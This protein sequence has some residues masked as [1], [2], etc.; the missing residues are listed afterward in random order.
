MIAPIF[1]EK[2]F[3]QHRTAFLLLSGF[4]LL[5]YFSILAANLLRSE[6][7]V[8][9]EQ[10]RGFIMIFAPIA[11]LILGEL[12]IRKEYGTKTQIFLEA[13]P[14]TRW[15]LVQTKFLLG[16]ALLA[17]MLLPACAI[18]FALAFGRQQMDARF[19]A[20]LLSRIGVF[21]LCWY[22]FF[23]ITNF[24]GRYR[25]PLYIF[26]GMGIVIITEMTQ[27]DL[28]RFGPIAL[29]NETFAFERENFPARELL[30]SLLLSL[31]FTAAGFALA[32]VREGSVAA[33]VAEK[34]SHRE[35]VFF[36]MTLLCF[37]LVGTYVDAKKPKPP[38]EL[39]GDISLTEGDATVKILL[40]EPASLEPGQRL[41]RD[42]VDELNAVKDWLAL[43]KL[44]ALNLIER[45]DLDP[46]QH[47]KGALDKSEGLL[48]RTNF[49]HPQWEKP[50]FVEKVIHDLL[51]DYS[52]GR[53]WLEGNHWILD[54]FALAW[55][56]RQHDSL[57]AQLW[58]RAL[59][60]TR[61][62]T[63][64]PD[65]QQ[66]MLLS[67]RLGDDI[68][69]AV[70]WSALQALEAVYGRPQLQQFLRRTLAAKPP[71]DLR[72]LWQG[73]NARSHNALAEIFGLDAA[74]FHQLWAEK[75]QAAAQQYAPA[76]KTIPRVQ[77]RLEQ[78]SLSEKT[79]RLEYRV[80]LGDTAARGETWVKFMYGKLERLAMYKSKQEL[81]R[82]LRKYDSAAAVELPETYD[83][84]SRLYCGVEI[85]NEALGCHLSAGWQI[86]EI[87]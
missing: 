10:L 60:G 72:V 30:E 66:W 58:Q 56:M 1:I 79:R 74:A 78:I 48:W 17:A 44:P 73:R 6:A 42:L 12:L 33:L 27:I 3:R 24:L 5:S 31:V 80:T 4:L 39:A 37:V 8:A 35:K 23:F 20:I 52:N 11:A 2:E 49:S 7:Q 51:A 84:G 41:C 26:I 62:E 57:A 55:S 83:L 53:A 15:R 77:L 16:L 75:L 63:E 81:Q 43:E 18:T 28:A 29:V 67:S 9:Q 65:V 38:F 46:D 40:A 45:R 86:L 19:A 32:L 25:F 54:G 59:V 13:L 69:S 36:A 71:K 64:L 47:E 50:K 85:Y 14:L 82:H 22:A 76:I 61:D 34:M 21:S 87:K 68:A 70:G